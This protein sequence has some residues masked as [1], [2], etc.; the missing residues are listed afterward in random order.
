MKTKMYHPNDWHQDWRETMAYPRCAYCGEKWLLHGE[1]NTCLGTGAY[2][3]CPSCGRWQLVPLPSGDSDVSR[4]P[5]IRKCEDS[6]AEPCDNSNCRASSS[7]GLHS[8][9][10]VGGA[11]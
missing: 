4:E 9:M 11:I 7:S 6:S 3:K 10:K 5:R 2:I 1:K 8:K